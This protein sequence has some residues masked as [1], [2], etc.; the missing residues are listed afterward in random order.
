MKQGIFSILGTIYFASAKN[1]FYYVGNNS[2]MIKPFTFFIALSYS[3]I[4]I[5]IGLIFSMFIIFDWLSKITDAIRNFFL[6]IIDKQSWSIDNSFLS[7]LIRPIILVILIPLFILS[8][9]IPRL[10]TNYIVHDVSIMLSATGT[11]KQINIIIYRAA[12]KL[13]VY[14]SAAPLLM[15]PFLAIIG[16]I[17]SIILIIFGTLFIFLIPLDWISKGIE[18]IRIYI[19]NFISK[20]Q[21]N[22]KYKVRAFLFTPIILTLFFPIILCILIIPKF[23]TNIITE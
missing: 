10:S 19:T 15:K 1:T 7:F 8:I 2:L 12:N 18:G 21:Y 13:F 17:Y 4:L 6:N 11:F 20:L 16:I 14:I 5:P 3:T 9:F 22:I 23:T